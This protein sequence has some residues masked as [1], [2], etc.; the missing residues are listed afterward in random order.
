MRIKLVIAS[1]PKVGEVWKAPNIH[2]A[3][4]HYI[5]FEFLEGDMKEEGDWE[6]GEGEKREEEGKFWK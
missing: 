6:K 1:I 4:L 3:A 5:F 2:K